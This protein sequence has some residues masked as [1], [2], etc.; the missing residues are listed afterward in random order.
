MKVCGK[1]WLPAIQPEGQAFPSQ[2]TWLD[3]AAAFNRSKSWSDKFLA[4][5]LEAGIVWKTK[6]GTYA[7]KGEQG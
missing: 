1:T 4:R 6:K 2:F 5:L 7:F 3:I